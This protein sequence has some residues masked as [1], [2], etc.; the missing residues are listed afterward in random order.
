MFKTHLFIN[1]VCQSF[2]ELDSDPVMFL[3]WISQ[4]ELQPETDYRYKSSG[5]ITTAFCENQ[6]LCCTYFASVKLEINLNT[7]M[8][9]DIDIDIH[10]H[11]TF[12]ERCLLNNY[13]HTTGYKHNKYT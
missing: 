10:I 7:W 6:T 1:D 13:R 4:A 11:F 8:E 3:I 2:A 12:P 5:N 9:L